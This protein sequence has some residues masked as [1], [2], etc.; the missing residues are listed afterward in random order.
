M[1]RVSTAA[2]PVAVDLR[3]VPELPGRGGRRW[4]NVMSG[5][6]AVYSGRPRPREVLIWRRLD[7]PA[8]TQQLQRKQQQQQ[9]RQLPSDD[10][11]PTTGPGWGQVG[12]NADRPAVCPFGAGTTTIPTDSC[13]LV[14]R[15]RR[16]AMYPSV[17]V[18]LSRVAFAGRGRRRGL[19]LCPCAFWSDDGKEG[20]RNV[21][22]GF[23][24][25]DIR[26]GPMRL[27]GNSMTVNVKRRL[28]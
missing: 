19:T 2:G 25:R 10:R 17:S 13:R 3:P 5:G 27:R 15:C 20:R 21:S 12:P 7:R 18:S 8:V 24:L 11:V 1:D 26:L 28:L 9:Q 16:D 14:G 6:W 22:F 23:V 4:P